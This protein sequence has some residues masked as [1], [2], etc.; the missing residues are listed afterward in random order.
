MRWWG[1]FVGWAVGVTGGAER[2]G[3]EE[4]RSR[5]TAEE[6]NRGTEERRKGG[7]VNR[8]VA[9]DVADQGMNLD[10]SFPPV[11][12]PPFHSSAAPL[13]LPPRVVKLKP[14]D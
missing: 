5:G 4:Q 11:P 9:R 1:F 10:T 14:V 12:V 13:F 2:R 3:T 8:K 6:R 7:R